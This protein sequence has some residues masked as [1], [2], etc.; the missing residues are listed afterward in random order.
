MSDELVPPQIVDEQLLVAN[1]HVRIVK[2]LFAGT[3][4]GI[5]QVL[6]GQPFDTTKVRLQTSMKNTT[7]M[8]V[9]K[10][11][12]KNEGLL[13]FYKG[14]L[15]PLVGVGACVSVQFGVNE[16]MKRFFNSRNNNGSKTLTLPQYYICGFTGG[17]V[18]SFLASPIEHVRIRLQTQTASSA[19]AE[20]K[21]PIDCIKKLVSQGQLMRGLPI[22]MLR[23]GH[24]VG[25]YFL[26]YESLIANQVNKGTPRTEIPPWKLCLFGAAA[27]TTLWMLVYPIDVIKSVVQSDNLKKPKFSTSLF[28]VGSDLYKRGG[29]PVFF[30]GFGVT[31]MRATPANA[32]TFTAFELAMRVM[33]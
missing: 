12:L 27:G 17:V 25:I 9:I 15:I 16:Y 22:M 21:G 7:Q 5:A 31:M 6:V 23:A 3:I 19:N 29:L 33:N 8:E 2:D 11:L 26:V 13:G 32:A 20:F 28:K 24:G 4:G 1:N 18:N 30:K 14:T 10:D